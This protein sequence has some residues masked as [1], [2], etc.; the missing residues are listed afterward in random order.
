MD[1]RNREHEEKKEEWIRQ[2][3]AVNDPTTLDKRLI[4]SI[5]ESPS[6]RA[7]G[8]RL[9]QLMNYTTD[10]E[11]HLFPGEK[12]RSKISKVSSVAFMGF[13]EPP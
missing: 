7:A 8:H 5:Q 6:E 4:L 13:H 3:C 10:G 1:L 2:V 12:C 9:D 11:R